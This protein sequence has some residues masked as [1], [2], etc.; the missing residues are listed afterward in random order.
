MLYNFIKSLKI[1]NICLKKK[2]LIKKNKKEEWN[3]IFMNKI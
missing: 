1:P 3:Q 2:C